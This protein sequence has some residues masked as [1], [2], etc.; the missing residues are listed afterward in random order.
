MITQINNSELNDFININTKNS[1]T[2]VLNESIDDYVNDYFSGFHDPT[3]R[4]L[5]H[6]D[7]ITFRSLVDYL[8]DIKLI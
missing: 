6:I 2:D 7:N 1:I 3:N 5:N 4:L 8:N